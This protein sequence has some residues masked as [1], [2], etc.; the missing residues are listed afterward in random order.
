M[1]VREHDRPSELLV[2]VTHVEAEPEVGL[3]RLVELRGGDSLRMRSAASGV[4][5]C[6]AVDRL[7]RVR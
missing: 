1:P 5:A 7:A 3:D 2:S 6:L 4:Y